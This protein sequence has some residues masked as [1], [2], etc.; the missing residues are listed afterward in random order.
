VHVTAL[1]ERGK[2][3]GGYGLDLVRKDYAGVVKGVGRAE[4]PTQKVKR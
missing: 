3:E 1:V 4:F 2:G